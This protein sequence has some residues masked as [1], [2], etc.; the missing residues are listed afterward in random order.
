MKLSE[1]MAKNP[2]I[3]GYT[4]EVMADDMI[5]A[6]D[7]SDDGTAA[8][9][10]YAVVLEHIS[11][12]TAAL[13]ATSKDSTYLRVGTSSAKTGNQRT[14]SVGGDRCIGDEFQDFALSHAIMYGTGQKVVRPY[15]YFNILT[16]K[17]E[18][19]Q[20][21]IIVNSD[22]GSAADEKASIDIELKKYG[23]TP[24]EYTY[25]ATA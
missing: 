16:G 9:G 3:V 6:I 12:V 20:I 11:S 21:A 23:A 19:G 10:D 24:V 5:L 17:G 14:F 25:S 7:V 1:L 4:G 18:Q 13:N 2:P 22:C 15:V 8:V